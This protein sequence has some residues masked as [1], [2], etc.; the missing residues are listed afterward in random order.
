MDWCVAGQ[1]GDSGVQGRGVMIFFLSRTEEQRARLFWIV[2]EDGR[3]KC[4]MTAE[5]S[6]YCK[7]LAPSPGSH[8]NEELAVRKE[9]RVT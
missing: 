5:R 7:A 4:L 8:I 2:P 1:F 3:D 9:T 6:I